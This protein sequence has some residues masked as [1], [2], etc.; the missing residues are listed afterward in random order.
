MAAPSPI[1][2]PVSSD[3]PAGIEL[4]VVEAL[5]KDVA[6]AVARMDPDDLKRLGVN[7]GDP[8]R[9]CAKRSTVCRAMPA[10]K[11][12]RGQGLV[13][14]D[15]L[16]R[17][18]CGC[19]LDERVSVAPTECK[20]ATT[21]SIVAA[22]GA[23]PAD[24]DLAYIGRLLDGLTV[25]SG[26]RIRAALFG[27]RSADF[28]VQKATPP[29]FVIISPQTRLLVERPAATSGAHASAGDA[30]H[31]AQAQ[32]ISYEDIG[33]LK[34]QLQRIRET[35][36]LPLR[37]PE[38]F[39]RLG[40]DPPKGVLL[41]GPP[42]CG[43]TLIARAIAQETD[44]AFYTISGPEVIHKFYGES[45]AALRRIW[46]EATKRSP[47]IIFLDEIDSIAPKRETAQGEVEKRVVA[48]LLS[49]MDGLKRRA[50]VMVIAATN[51]PNNIDPALR[52]P[53]RFDREISIPIPDRAS[54][55][56]II[57]IHS[58]GM[59]LAADVDLD[60][61]ADVTHGYVGADLEA[62]CR[63]GA[64]ACLRQIMHEINFGDAQIPYET[65]AKLEVTMAHFR[66]AT[67]EIE[68]SAVREVLV[69]TPNVNWDD[70]GGLT[71][72]KQRLVEAVE[73]PLKHAELFRAA[74]VRPPKGILLVGPP[75]VGKTMLAKAVASQ[76]EANFISVKG[77]ELISKFVGDS[78]RGVREI[79]RKA[80]RAS[81]CII[82]FDE[83]DALIPA[84][85]AGDATGVSNRV[86]AQFLAEMDGVEE[87]RNVLVLGATN[88]LDMLDPAMLRP[89]RFDQVIEIGAPD[90]QGR[91]EIF[92]VHLATKPLR[93]TIN[94][95]QLAQRAPGA[96]G[97]Q[98]AGVC[99]RAA[100]L[101]L[102]RTITA[103]AHG[104]PTTPVEITQDDLDAA[105]REELER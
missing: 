101:A 71:D 78:E 41:H 73:W 53:G 17:T 105:L 51:L 34:P 42:G 47:S 24:R 89:G 92:R 103:H 8:V 4:R 87:L 80:R 14:L 95:V 31:N 65:L 58:R 20:P 52:R 70:I 88:R 11:E 16:S 97:A 81:P 63:E 86:L 69:E 67:S 62:L 79:F 43:K 27:S 18:N 83:I 60:R 9:V 23:P 93:G 75:G 64:M 100:M 76:A 54:R 44:A 49:L 10:F 32:G 59:P 77:P 57:E 104:A 98:I 84:R 50:G 66:Q 35:I 2:P 37:Y 61:L 29:G 99:A 102:R 38:V 68:P 1:K 7:I 33:G 55:R 15:G 6:R 26:D 30:R 40:I 19:G 74:D 25:T 91:A 85:S 39:E 5:N 94:P 28:I 48:Q 90:E 36:E 12:Q 96:T 22:S 82:F 3:A 56:H 21:V 45:E 72:T 13:Q 46:D